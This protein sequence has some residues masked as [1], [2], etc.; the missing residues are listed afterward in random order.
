MVSGE[1]DE[2]IR[3]T[4]PEIGA[5]E[6]DAVAAV[7]RSGYLVQGG[8]VRELERLV[9]EYVGARYAVAVSSGTAALHLALLALGI[10]PGDEVIVPDFTFPATANV[11]EL[12]GAKPV[13]VDIDLATFNVDV[14]QIRSAITSRTKAIMPVHLFGQ[15]ADM[16]FVLQIA[17]EYHLLVIEDAACALGAEHRGHKCGTMGH[18]G[19]FSFHPRKAITTGEGGMVVTND[20]IVAELVRC[21]RNHGMVTTNGHKRFEMVGFNYRMTDLQ[22]ALGV[23]QMGRLEGII[24]RRRDLAKLYDRMLAGVEAVVCPSEM[25]G[26]RHIWQSYVVVL[27]EG[28]RRDG[29]ID[30]LREQG[31][32][33][34]I[35]TYAVSVQ[36]HY[37]RAASSVPPNSR[38]A[39]ERSLCL[40][41]HPRMS[42]ADVEKVS[43]CLEKAVRSESS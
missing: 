34:T 20:K 28:V 8:Q 39:Y 42:A 25:E 21:L 35:G 5:E 9:A 2:V 41:L 29:I 4:I 13:L 14:S 12:V 31:V 24:A 43:R 18:V 40:P 17:Q 22:G 26:V 32:E 27:P 3:L 6:I 15:P 10:G 7:L 37:A 38:Q 33:T 1:D 23:V 36:P 30:T 16:E 11:V 19:C